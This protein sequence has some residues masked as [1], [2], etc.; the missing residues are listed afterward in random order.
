MESMHELM[1][2]L[3]SNDVTHVVIAHLKKGIFSVVIDEN[4]RLVGRGSTIEKAA[5]EALKKHNALEKFDSL[6]SP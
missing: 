2:K 3:V 6:Q 5:A 4:A 1:N